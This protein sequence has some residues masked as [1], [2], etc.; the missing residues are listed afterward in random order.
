MVAISFAVTRLPFNTIVVEEPPK[1]IYVGQ[2]NGF[3]SSGENVLLREPLLLENGVFSNIG[4]ILKVR[5]EDTSVLQVQF[6]VR[7]SQEQ[8]A[9]TENLPSL[10]PP[11]SRTYIAYPP[12]VLLTHYVRWVRSR[13]VVSEAFVFPQ[14][15]IEDGTAS[16][17]V[18]MSNAFILRYHTI[19]DN[20]TAVAPVLL[21]LQGEGEFKTFPEHDNFSKSRWHLVQRIGKSLVDGLCHMSL[22]ARLSKSIKLVLS[23]EEWAYIMRRLGDSVNPIQRKGV[24]TVRVTRRW[25]SR[26][27]IKHQST[28]TVIRLDTS[29]Q[30][31]RLK[32]VFG[33][34][35]TVGLRKVPPPTPK[36]RARDRYSHSATVMEDNDWVNTMAS[37][38]VAHEPP[39]IPYTNYTKVRGID[40]I[41]DPIACQLQLKI[42]FARL[43]S[44][45]LRVHAELGITINPNAPLAGEGNIN[46][47]VGSTFEFEEVIYRVTRIDGINISCLVEESENMHVHRDDTVIFPLPDVLLYVTEYATM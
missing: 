10:R 18:G 32:S 33:S 36:L 26:E 13:S 45:D 30:M 6:F 16:I 15:A 42:R 4:R 34:T 24:S 43:K 22:A 35:V 19:L 9:C 47:V 21:V 23:P 44:E 39:G 27:A 46:V 2:M 28:K 7:A 3:L 17:S 25:A 5:V 29:V 31:A 1:S 20:P 8:L 38:P 12:E 37:L 41:Y 11:A 40:F 14:S